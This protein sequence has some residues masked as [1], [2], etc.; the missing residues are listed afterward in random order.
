MRNRLRHFEEFFGHLGEW[1]H[2]SYGKAE[3]LVFGKYF[4]DSPRKSAMALPMC[5]QSLGTEDGLG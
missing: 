3:E 2:S 4:D 1:P 5:Q